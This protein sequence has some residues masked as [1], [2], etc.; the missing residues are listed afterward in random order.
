MKGFYKM[1]K[2]FNISD[3]LAVKG[4]AVFLLLVHHLIGNK[5]YFKQH[6]L[7]GGVTHNK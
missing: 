2:K 3:S 6:V 7:S 5:D 4:I 1:E